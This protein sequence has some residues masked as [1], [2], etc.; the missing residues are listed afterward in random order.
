MGSIK[1]DVKNLVNISKIKQL[2]KE[3]GKTITY[4]CK[5]IGQGPWYLNDVAQEKTTI[6]DEDLAIIA[7]ILN[8]TPE[9]LRDETDQKEKSATEE[10]PLPDILYRYNELSEDKQREVVSFI[11][12]KLAQQKKKPD[13]YIGQIAAFG[14]GPVKIKGANQNA[15]KKAA[16][17]AQKRKAEKKKK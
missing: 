13:D 9:Y 10:K 7:D 5:C 14:S 8:T 16:A 1:K 4:V 11:E 3:Q 2:T 17:L 6:S 15:V 12:F